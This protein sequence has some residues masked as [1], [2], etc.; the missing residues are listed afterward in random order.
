MVGLLKKS[1]TF[2]QSPRLIRGC[3]SI[4][5]GQKCVVFL[6][7]IFQLQTRSGSATAR[8]LKTRSAN[9]IECSLKRGIVTQPELTCQELTELITDYLEERLSQTDRIRF[10]QHLSVCSGCVTYVDQMRVTIQAMGSKPPL[11]IPSSIEA[12]LLEAFRRWKN[13]NH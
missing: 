12:P 10:E 13:P 6:R 7:L 3:C 11:K 2:W 5:R 9:A 1:V 4:G 8:S